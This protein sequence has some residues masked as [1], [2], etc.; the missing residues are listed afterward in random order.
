M[1][2]KVRQC[3]IVTY[4]LSSDDSVMLLLLLNCFHEVNI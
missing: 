1:I 4:T 3:D 2:I